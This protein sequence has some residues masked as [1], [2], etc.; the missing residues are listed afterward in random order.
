GSLGGGSE[1]LPFPL[2]PFDAHRA[3]PSN[4]SAESSMSN[5]SWPSI[6]E[7]PTKSFLGPPPDSFLALVSEPGPEEFVRDTLACSY[8]P[9]D[10]ASDKRQSRG[11][12]NHVTH[13]TP[14]HKAIQRCPPGAFSRDG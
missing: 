7:E 13:F 14:R 12:K 2:P 5:E 11:R 9:P 6:T 10:S 3:G 8:P 4:Y 1:T